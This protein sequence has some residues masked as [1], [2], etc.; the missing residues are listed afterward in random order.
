[1]WSL[2]QK[3]EDCESRDSERGYPITKDGELQPGGNNG[4][5]LQ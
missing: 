2:R 4:R 1:L 3:P 5:K